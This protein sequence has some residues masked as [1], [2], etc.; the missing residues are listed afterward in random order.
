MTDQLREIGGRLAALREIEGIS[1]QE[2]AAHCDVPAEQIEAYERGERDFSFSFLYN[3]ARALRVD[4]V[5]LMSGDSPKLSGCCLTRAGEGYAIDRRAAY[6]YKHLAFT[7]RDK[8]AEPFM[9]TVEPTGEPPEAMA[10]A[11]AGTEIKPVQHAHSGQ[12][13]NLMVEGRM[14]F[15]MGELAYDLNPGDSI[16]FNASNAHAMRALDGK[17]AKFLA[18]VMQKGD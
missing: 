15:F 7:F 14:R 6:S 3:A 16:Y 5:D 4:V 8:L 9:V 2:L 17:P 18:I 1:R 10:A 12:E 11:A 13:F